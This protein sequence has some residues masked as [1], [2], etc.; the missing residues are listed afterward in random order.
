[1][2]LPTVGRSEYLHEAVASVT[3]QTVADFECIVVDDS[4]L[5]RIEDFD[6]PRVVLVRLEANSG[7][8]AARNVG[9]ERATGTYIAFLDDDDLYTGRRLE[10]GLEGLKGGD[11]AICWRGDVR[12]RAGR[13][14][15]L[16]G[17]VYDE[18]LDDLVP[19]LGQVTIRRTLALPFN[20][21]FRAAEDVEWWLRVAK[22]AHVATIPQVGYLYRTRGGHPNEEAT[23]QRLASSFLLMDVHKAYFERHPRAEAFRWKRI[24]LLAERVDKRSL[25]RRA[26]LHSLRKAPTAAG[27]K[28]LVR[29]VLPRSPRSS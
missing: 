16:Q 22:E 13:N 8:A 24:G 6:D 28:H 18:I 5:G 29:S 10:L 23:A 25:A 1:M 17:N 12:G 20:E 2:I 7:P 26:F 15:R 3:S 27:V 14:R 11:V 21:A 4:G 9:L 19:H